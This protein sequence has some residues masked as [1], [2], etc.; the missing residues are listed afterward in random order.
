MTEVL[1]NPESAMTYYKQACSTAAPDDHFNLGYAKMRIGC[2]Y[3]DYL[4]MD[5]ADILNLKQALHHFEQVPD[6]YY[7]NHWMSFVLF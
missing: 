5:S 3:R 4:V 2:L 7:I 6:S 1:G